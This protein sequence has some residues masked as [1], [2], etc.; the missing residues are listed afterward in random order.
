MSIELAQSNHIKKVIR[1]NHN[2]KIEAQSIDL[3]ACFSDTSKGQTPTSDNDTTYEGN[4]MQNFNN[5]YKQPKS[6]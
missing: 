1:K 6:I 4:R 2:I 5:K 3:L